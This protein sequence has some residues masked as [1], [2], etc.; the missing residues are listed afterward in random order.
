[1]A[2]KEI[3][4]QMPNAALIAMTIAEIVQITELLGLSLRAT[5]IIITL[6][7]PYLYLN[8]TLTRLALL[9]KTKKLRVRLY[10][11]RRRQTDFVAKFNYLKQSFKSKQRFPYPCFWYN[12]IACG[13]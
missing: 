10:D 2:Y 13:D 9:D 7:P 3:C 5:L 1:M 8:L 4:K 11:V 12:L 6:P